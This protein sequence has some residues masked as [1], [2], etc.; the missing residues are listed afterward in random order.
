ML[1]C[2]SL[3]R[4]FQLRKHY[5]GKSSAEV[6]SL[7]KQE[8]T[9]G[10]L[11]DSTPGGGYFRVLNL[12]IGLKVL[13]FFIA[14][15]YIFIDYRY[16]GKG[17]TMTRHQRDMAEQQIVAESRTQTDPLTK[18]FPVRNVTICGIIML[19]A[20]LITAWVLFFMGLAG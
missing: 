14:L 16:L 15:I 4:V 2:I 5:H 1:I 18:R 13:A 20:L 11:Q 6:V 8:V 19:A 17:L 3:A 7:T 10:K 12:A 9:F